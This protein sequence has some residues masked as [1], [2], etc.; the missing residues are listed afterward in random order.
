MKYVRLSLAAVVLFT[1]MAASSGQA[2]PVSGAIANLVPRQVF[3]RRQP[4]YWR[5]HGTIAAGGGMVIATAGDAKAPNRG[6]VPK[7]T[8]P[9]FVKNWNE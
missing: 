8:A 2:A 4:S 5:R 1:C 7:G 3:C 9:F 6:A